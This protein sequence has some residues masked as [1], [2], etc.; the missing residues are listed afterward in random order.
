MKCCP[1]SASSSA[2][3]SYRNMVYVVITCVWVNEGPR[4]HWDGRKLSLFSKSQGLTVKEE[5]NSSRARKKYVSSSVP[6]LESDKTFPWTLVLWGDDIY[7]VT[8][9]VGVQPWLNSDGNFNQVGRRWKSPKQQVPKSVV[10]R[11]VCVREG[12][13]CVCLSW[14][15][16]IQKLELQ[17]ETGQSLP[18]LSS[19][20]AYEPP[21]TL[22]RRNKLKLRSGSGGGCWGFAMNEVFVRLLWCLQSGTALVQLSLQIHQPWGTSPLETKRSCFQ[23]SQD[24][25]AL[26][27]LQNQRLIRMA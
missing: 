21:E 12:T 25:E 23:H 9:D 10:I 3:V 1:L 18:I 24:D 13:L 14:A 16:M 2:Q 7:V 27:C 17:E 20:H 22:C 11:D 4:S 19:I 26:Q 5:R 8:A 6:P 15:A